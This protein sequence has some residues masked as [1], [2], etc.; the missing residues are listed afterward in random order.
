MNEFHTYSPEGHIQ[1][2]IFMLK[3][4]SKITED[5]SKKLVEFNYSVYGDRANDFYGE[6]FYFSVYLD[7]AYSQIVASGISTFFE[8]LFKHEFNN[9]KSE[10]GTK[11]PINSSPR[12]KLDDKH[13]WNPKKVAEPNGNLAKKDSLV[14]GIIQLVEALGIPISIQNEKWVKIK[15]LFHYRNYLMHNGLEWTRKKILEF[16]SLIKNLGG[17][18]CF[19]RATSGERTWIIYLSKAFENELIELAIQC[20]RDFDHWFW[21]RV[22]EFQK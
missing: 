8:S 20:V 15:I 9:L 18:S 13:F 4:A 21:K 6:D 1:A 17:E 5:Q 10:F 11:S 22:D 2:L 7:A 16:E 19:S 14:E 12:W 3:E